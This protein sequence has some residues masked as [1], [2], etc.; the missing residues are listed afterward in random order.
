MDWNNVKEKVSVLLVEDDEDDI[1]LVKRAFEKGKILNKLYVVHDGEEAI[2]FLRHTGRYANKAE[3]PRPGFILL[4]L[5]MPRM[6]GREILDI[7][8]KDESLHRIPVIILTTSSEKKDVFESYDH[9]ANTYITKPVEFS[10]FLDAIM[11]LGRYW[12]SIA[13]VPNGEELVKNQK[14]KSDFGD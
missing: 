11:T 4:D 3:A 13:E 2:E 14:V 12:L 6:T 7:I 10:K 1:S 8:K 5:N 9:G